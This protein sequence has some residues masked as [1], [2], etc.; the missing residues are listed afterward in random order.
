M[1]LLWSYFNLQL[2]NEP[3]SKSLWFVSKTLWKLDEHLNVGVLYIAR[4]IFF[5]LPTIFEEFAFPTITLNFPIWSLFLTFEYSILYLIYSVLSHELL[6]PF[7]AFSNQIS[8]N[9]WLFS[10]PILLCLIMRRV[11][12]YEFVS[13]KY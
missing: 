13:I 8:N 9:I 2:I 11:K 7:L 4:T 6:P 5:P 3:I 10:F 12:S 1:N